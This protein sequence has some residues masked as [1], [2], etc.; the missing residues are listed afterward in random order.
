MTGISED[1]LDFGSIDVYYIARQVNNN[2]Y[3][4]L[5]MTPKFDKILWSTNRRESFYF[6]TENE[7]HKHSQA[8]K[9][10]RPD[11]AVVMAELDVIEELI[12]FSS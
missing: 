8:I 7:A 12:G 1:L 2:T 4:M 5:D 10:T 6:Y 9:R 3:F 11:V